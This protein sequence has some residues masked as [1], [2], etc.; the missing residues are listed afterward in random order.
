MPTWSQMAAGSVTQTK[1]QIYSATDERI[2]SLWIGPANGS[3]WTIRDAGGQVLRR[4]HKSTSGQWSWQ[5]DYVYRDGQMLASEVATREKTLHYH[6]DH[7]GTPRLITGNGGAQVALHTYDPFGGELTAANQ[8]G[9]EPIKK[10]TGHERDTANV[11]YMHARYYQNGWGRFL[12]VDPMMDLEKA[13]SGPQQW[14]RYAYASNN[15]AGRVDPDGRKDKLFFFSA[16]GFNDS[17][18]SKSGVQDAAR[19]AGKSTEIVQRATRDEIIEGS[20]RIDGTGT[21]VLVIA[22]HTFD[23]K[24]LGKHD[25][26]ATW[27]L[28]GWGSLKANDIANAVGDGKPA[29]IVL[30]GCSTA[31]MAQDVANATGVPTLGTSGDFNQLQGFSDVGQVIDDALKGRNG[32]LSDGTEY[33]VFTQM[34]PTP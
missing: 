14:N 8:A 4:L 34:S 31:G 2:A 1:V 24:K 30:L 20:G 25:T 29:A 12:S 22:A 10:F 3:D 21:D 26:I 33:R 17:S 7:L 18:P 13:I 27:Q 19:R 15:P 23:N 32:E 9:T 6:L 11:D 28:S 16:V 5:E